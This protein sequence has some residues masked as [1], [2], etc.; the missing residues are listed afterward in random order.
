MKR[1]SFLKFLGLAPAA[2]IVAQIPAVQAAVVKVA[3]PVVVAAAVDHGWDS[4]TMVSI[5]TSSE[6]LT[7]WSASLTDF[8]G[9]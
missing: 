3:A 1:R 5:S 8:K 9:K 4:T 6:N 7:Y 2:P